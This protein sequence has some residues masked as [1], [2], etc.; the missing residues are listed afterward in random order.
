MTTN[1]LTIDRNRDEHFYEEVRRKR[2][3]KLS[4]EEGISESDRIKQLKIETDKINEKMS[5]KEREAKHT[6]DH[7]LKQ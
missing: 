1:Y 2:L 3:A 4:K 5:Q 6:K 7:K